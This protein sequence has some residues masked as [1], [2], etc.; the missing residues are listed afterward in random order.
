[1]P[2]FGSD[3]MPQ[4]RAMP[5]GASPFNNNARSEFGGRRR[6]Y[7]DIVKFEKDYIGSLPSAAPVL[8]KTE[9]YFQKRLIAEK[10]ALMEEQ[11]VRFMV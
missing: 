3:S 2:Y 7:Q 8:S 9:E 4:S 10:Q 6:P 1:M 5:P 11:T